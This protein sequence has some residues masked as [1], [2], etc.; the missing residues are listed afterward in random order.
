[1]SSNYA[2]S[3]RG[4]GMSRRVRST[5]HRQKLE[6][7]EPH[8]AIGLFSLHG[9]G[10][11]CHGHGHTSWPLFHVFWTSMPCWLMLP[12]TSCGGLRAAAIDLW[13]RASTCVMPILCQLHWQLNCRFQSVSNCSRL[14]TCWLHFFGFLGVD[15]LEVCVFDPCRCGA[16]ARHLSPGANLD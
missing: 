8:V 13:E 11:L 15:L 1:M 2:N 10:S 6:F 9:H 3:P 4:K 5:C 14:P 7:G 12:Q 16:R